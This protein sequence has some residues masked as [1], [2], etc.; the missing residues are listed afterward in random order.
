MYAYAARKR[1][2]PPYAD[3]PFVGLGGKRFTIEDAKQVFIFDERTEADFLSE[4][5]D[6]SFPIHFVLAKTGMR[7]GEL[8]HLLIEDLDLA[9]G[10]LRISNKPELGWRIKTRRERDIPLVSEVIGVLRRVIRDRTHGPVFVRQRFDATMLP[11]ANADRD[12]LARA[13][14]DRLT[15]AE[16][17]SSSL[18]TRERQAKI[19]RSVWR[20]AGIVSTDAVRNSYIRIMQ[21][22]GTPHA[23]CPKCWR[24][25][26]ATLLQDAGVDPLVRQITL[27]HAPTNS[28]NRPPPWGSTCVLSIN[29]Q[30]N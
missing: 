25:T 17:Q 30:P 10:W 15:D 7:P 14:E 18:L 19:A 29:Q 20:D 3:N 11:L 5:D 13:L 23:T 1:H 2:L 9:A 8:I 22:L 6:W 28:Y 4:A 12:M 26:F 27:G 21:V 24:H 16:S